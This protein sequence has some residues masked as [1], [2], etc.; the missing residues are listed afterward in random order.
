MEGDKKKCDCKY[1]LHL[2]YATVCDLGIIFVFVPPKAETT[3]ILYQTEKTVYFQFVIEQLCNIYR[4]TANELR[5]A[6]GFH[7]CPF[8]ENH[9]T[10]ITRT[11][12]YKY[13]ETHTTETDSTPPFHIR[14]PEIDKKPVQITQ[15]REHTFLKREA[16]SRQITVETI[17]TSHI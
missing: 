7:L 12:T 1:R 6:H 9:T 3:G 13:S 17:F 11:H 10:E 14:V 2:S 4:R 16:L 5:V 8:Q 15:T